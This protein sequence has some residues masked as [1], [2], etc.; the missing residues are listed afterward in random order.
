MITIIVFMCCLHVTSA[1]PA[2]GLLGQV[3]DLGGATRLCR[4]VH[5]EVLAAYDGAARV[6]KVP[7]FVEL[8]RVLAAEVCEGDVG[9]EGEKGDRVSLACDSQGTA[10]CFLAR[11]SWMLVRLYLVVL[12]GVMPASASHL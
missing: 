3:V 4:R 7:E 5:G 2:T 6:V 8:G 9:G 1:F 10:P 11:A 12:L